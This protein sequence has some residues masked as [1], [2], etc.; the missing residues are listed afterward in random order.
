V[1]NAGSSLHR[2]LPLI[3][4]ATTIATVA[5]FGLFAYRTVRTAA[6]ASTETRLRSAAGEI[7]SIMGLGSVNVLTTLELVARDPAVITALTRS[8]SVP[9]DSTARALRALEGRTGAALAVELLDRQG[10]IRATTNALAGG[11]PALD[12]SPNDTAARVGPFFRRDS[13]VLFQAFAPVRAN[14]MLLGEIRLTRR[15]A[16]ANANQRIVQSLLGHDAA[17]LIGNQDGS[18]W[19]EG[20]RPVPHPGVRDESIRYERDGRRWIS[21]SA[22]LMKTPWAIATELPEESALAGAQQ[23]LIPFVVVGVFVSVA[24]ALV[25]AWLSR[26]MTRPL[27]EL[28]AVS[29][30]MAGGDLSVKEVVVNEDDEIGRL[31]RAFAAMAASIRGSRDRLEGEIAARTGELRAA[32]SQLRDAQDDLLK[33]E[34]LAAIG[35]L[36]ASIGHELRNPLAVMSNCVYLL[37]MSRE[38]TPQSKEY[39]AILRE[40]IRI[41]QRIISDLLSNVHSTMPVRSLV[42][43][44]DLIEVYLGQLPMPA[45]IRVERQIQAD[46]PMLIVDPD[47][48]G[49]VLVNL[50]SNAVQAMEGSDVGGV[51][52]LRAEARDARVVIEVSDTGPGVPDSMADRI[53][54]PLY[55]TKARGIGLGLSVAR[56]MARANSGDLRLERGRERG[57]CFVFELPVREREDFSVAAV[58]SHAT[59]LEAPARAPV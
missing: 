23:V 7:T 26:T 59:S 43:V 42:N 10:R 20:N 40:Q 57:A 11:S 18:V 44:A 37:E 49:R 53:F 29:E 5:V 6:M 15:T 25:G 4:A 19:L 41:S 14:G 17:L 54:E 12:V 51:L 22:A 39:A 55:T 35:R 24:G 47:Q 36:S 21:V 31:A 50:V 28:T 30:A 3:I 45:S 38:I 48:V 16:P 46:L 56:E 1:R 9:S 33:K 13:L 58:S 27:V 34:R 2:R 52:T 8:S 32:L